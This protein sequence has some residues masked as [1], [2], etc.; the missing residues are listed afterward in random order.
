MAEQAS[1]TVDDMIVTSNDATQA[2]LEAEFAPSEQAETPPGAASEAESADPAAEKP[3]APKK[4]PRN[5]PTARMLDATAKE[6][7][8]KRERDEARREAAELKARLDALERRPQPQ[9][10]QE[11]PQQAPPT[12][13]GRAAE[14]QRYKAMPDAPKLA[15]FEGP[16]AFEDWQ[17]AMNVF[18]ADKRYEER[19]QFDVLQAQRQRLHQVETEHFRTFQGKLQQATTEDPEFL[20]KIDK[21]LTETPRLSA[22][23]PHMRPTFGNFL[24]EQ[25][26]RSEAPKELL[27]HFTAHPDDVQ[28]LAS[29][30][31]DRVVREIARLEERLAPPAAS[32]K[33]GTAAGPPRSQAKPPI[34]PVTG[35]SQS[36]SDDGGSDD[37]P[38]EAYIR[39]ENAKEQRQ[40]RAS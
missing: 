12:K 11:Q 27:V 17:V 38:V 39:R 4:S 37:E 1:V 21:R 35:S 31:P 16:E 18:V 2:E 9:P 33:T 7:A 28:R 13:E 32:S 40:R 24:V 26:Y 34:T 10:Q 30:P 36:A 6:A 23:P 15:Q 25:I 14:W 29:L 3:A 20:S 8:A 5:D 22:L 19:R